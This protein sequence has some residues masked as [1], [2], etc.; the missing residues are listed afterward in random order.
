MILRIFNLNF[1]EWIFHYLLNQFPTA[2][3]LLPPCVIVNN[4]TNVFKQVT[5]FI[6]TM[7][8][9]NIR[10]FS[11]YT[12]KNN[13]SRTITRAI[14]MNQPLIADTVLKFT[15]DGGVLES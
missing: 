14:Y 1:F 4:G 15:G 11:L 5:Y 9:F 8:V 7:K 2:I 3:R 6:S 12:H 13:N 10:N